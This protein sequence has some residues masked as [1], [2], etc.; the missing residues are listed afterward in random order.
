M[1]A[2]QFPGKGSTAFDAT[3]ET[4]VSLEI[5]EKTDLFTQVNALKSKIFIDSFMVTRATFDLRDGASLTYRGETDK[6]PDSWSIHLEFKE[7]DRDIDADFG[8]Q[9]NE[10]SGELEPFVSRR[11]P[12]NGDAL[13]RIKGQNAV[14][15]INSDLDKLLAPFP[16]YIRTRAGVHTFYA[17]RDGSGPTRVTDGGIKSF[18]ESYLELFGMEAFERYKREEAEKAE[19]LVRRAEEQAPFLADVNRLRESVGILQPGVYVRE[20][21]L[22]L[23]NGDVMRYATGSEEYPDFWHLTI[24]Q[25]GKSGIPYFS[26]GTQLVRVPNS[27]SYVLEPAALVFIPSSQTDSS[28]DDGVTE[29]GRS[30]IPKIEGFLN[31]IFSN[32]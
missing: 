23:K 12:V 10:D 32:Q 8:F 20:S 27:F 5:T 28:R 29:E 25:D 26:F 21:E 18:E 14:Q 9:I 1:T 4:T 19:V 31:E 15:A 7:A 24:F 3:A 11:F 6:Q 30:V 13:V 2:D 16:P 22:N 17:D